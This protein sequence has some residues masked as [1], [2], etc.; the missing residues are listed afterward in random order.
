M[1]YSGSEGQFC[2]DWDGKISDA[3]N[4]SD[5]AGDLKEMK[6]GCRE[7]VMVVFILGVE[8]QLHLSDKTCS[9]AAS[10]NERVII[11]LP[12]FKNTPDT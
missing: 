5:F 12:P 6:M 11:L 9:R 10:Q 1:S 2:H 3:S 7:V 4:I 8:R